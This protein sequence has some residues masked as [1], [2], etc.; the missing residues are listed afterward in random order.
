M[1]LFDVGAVVQV[2]PWDDIYVVQS[3]AIASSFCDRAPF[4]FH[5]KKLLVDGGVAYGIAGVITEFSSTFEGL[6]C[7]AIFR[8]DGS[9]WCKECC[10]DAYI[11]IG[12]SMVQRNYNF[13]VRHPDGTCMEGYPS[14]SLIGEVVVIKDS[15]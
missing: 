8:S 7:N 3:K 1:P 9:D 6:I 13:D 2:N 12:S 14:Y 15:S 5:V 11:K 10:G 4:C